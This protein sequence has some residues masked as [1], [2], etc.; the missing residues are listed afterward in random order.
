VA[1]VNRMEKALATLVAQSLRGRSVREVADLCGL[2]DHQLRDIVYGRTLLPRPDVLEAISKGLGVP[3]DTL[4]L[5]AYGV[6]APPSSLGRT[7]QEEPQCS[8]PESPRRR[9]KPIAST[10]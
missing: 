9:Q 1:K 3:Y 5:A 6:I 8:P 10:S 2:P 7:E 4:A